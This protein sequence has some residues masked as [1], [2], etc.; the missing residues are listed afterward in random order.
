MKIKPTTQPTL[1]RWVLSVL[2]AIAL[3]PAANAANL[4]V[5]MSAETNDPAPSATLVGPAGGLGE[6]WNQ[7]STSS[8]AG[9]L[10][11]TGAASTVGYTSTNLGGPDKWGSDLTLGMIWS[12]WRNFSTGP[13]NSQQLVINGLSTGDL[14]NVWIASANVLSGQRSSG[15]WTTPNNT[16]TVGRQVASNISGVID[17]TWV[18]G[19]NYVLFENVEVDGSGELVFNEHSDPSAEVGFESR[20][21]MNGF[22][23]VQVPEPTAVLLGGL[24]LLALLRRRRAYGFRIKSDFQ[25]TGPSVHSDGPFFWRSVKMCMTK[26]G[27]RLPF[28]SFWQSP[29]DSRDPIGI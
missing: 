4:I 10:D 19:N 22:Q 13:A 21:P 8:A 6:T 15:T 17:D 18:E 27:V 20:L 5:N 11:S 14:F 24:G 12:G 7:F 9:L 2:A 23:L 25:F 29:V 28:E 16:T 3:V 26:F 1:S